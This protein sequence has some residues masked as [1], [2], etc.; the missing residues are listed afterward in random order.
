MNTEILH[1]LAVDAMKNAYAPYSTYKVG[2]SIKSSNHK[3]YAGCNVENAAYPQGLCAEAG[4]IASMITGGCRIISDVLI[5]SEGQELVV[6]CGGCRQKLLEF[7]NQET[8]ILLASYS[9]IE[10]KLSI[11]DLL[12]LSFDKTFLNH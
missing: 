9:K 7:S 11:E 2:A 8:T 6:P 4:A 1:R 10:K 3:F 12:P 5:V